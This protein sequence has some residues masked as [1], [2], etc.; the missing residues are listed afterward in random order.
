ME[1]SYAFILQC[2][3]GGSTV[4]NS[5]DL[6]LA[7]NKNIS[8]EI[9]QNQGW[10]I[11]EIFE[12]TALVLWH[13]LYCHYHDHQNHWTMIMIMFI[14]IRLMMITMFVLW[15]CLQWRS[16]P[17][18]DRSLLII[19]G[20]AAMLIMIDDH[21]HGDYHHGNVI[22]DTVT[23]MM[24]RYHHCCHHGHRWSCIFIVIVGHCDSDDDEPVS[25]FLSSTIW[26]SQ[27]IKTFY[28]AHSPHHLWFCLKTVCL[29]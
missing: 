20:I 25:F 22:L 29:L 28:H 2:T 19:I 18:A 12:I 26:W 7:P 15:H 8:E 13:C 14:M 23:T 27:M 5:K 21:H 11:L 6:T 3:E 10:L 1:I 24:N 16:P 9:F 4:S 17:F